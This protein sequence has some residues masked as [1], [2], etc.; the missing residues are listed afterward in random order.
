MQNIDYSVYLVTDRHCLRGRNFYAAVEEALQSGVTLVQL[1]EKTLTPEELLLEGQKM[2]ALC[3]RYGVPLLIDDQ[4]EVAKALGCAGVH[5]GQDDDA[6]TKA[7][8]LLGTEAVIGISAH[9]LE[10]AV[11]AEKAGAAYLG[12]GALYPTGSK[13]DA[14]LLPA[15]M[16]RKITETVHIPV[17]GIG[18]IH[19][20]QYQEVL[21]QGAAGCAMISGILGA[22]DITAT[23]HRLK[24][25]AAACGK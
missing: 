3:R 1:R 20:A 5:L 18:G 8:R 13:K 25:A 24:K 9:N 21:A 23:V 2:L 15:G 11:A 16:L 6:I 22:D 4:I 10:E 12:V 19:E 7:Q 17:V 14:K